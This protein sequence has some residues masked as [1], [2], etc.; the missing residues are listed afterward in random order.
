MSTPNS[1]TDTKPTFK[2]RVEYETPDGKW[3]SNEGERDFTVP[4]ELSKIQITTV[5]ADGE[6]QVKTDCR[7]KRRIAASKEDILTYLENDPLCTIS[8]F[9]Y[10]YDLFA[11]GVIKVP[12]QTAIEGPGKQIQKIA[13]QIF[14]SR[15]KIGYPVTQAEALQLARVASGILE[16]HTKPTAQLT[17]EEEL[18]A[19]TEA[20]GV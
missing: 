2:V 1:S 4:N 13:E 7:F 12:L 5:A 16:P 10:G 3:Q 17:E 11:R 19:Q 18:E 20:S 14:D 6:T 9:N 15:A 8:A